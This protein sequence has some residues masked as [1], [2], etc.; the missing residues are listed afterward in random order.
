MFTTVACG[1]VYE[2]ASEKVV[3]S[4]H[5]LFK[6]FLI[7]LCCLFG[8]LGGR[9]KNHAHFIRQEDIFIVPFTS[10][11]LRRVETNV[12]FDYKKAKETLTLSGRVKRPSHN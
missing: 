2:M 7:H 4:F 11:F 1:L 12:P 3:T 8:T 9:G 5:Q 6:I 10:I